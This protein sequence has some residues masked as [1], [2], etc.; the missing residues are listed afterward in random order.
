MSLIQKPEG[1]KWCLLEEDECPGAMFQVPV[2]EEDDVPW[3]TAS[4]S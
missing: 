2:S 3:E 4:I 1:S